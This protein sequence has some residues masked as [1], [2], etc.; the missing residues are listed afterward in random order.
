L[1]TGEVV[2]LVRA[3]AE[4]FVCLIR[5][6][7]GRPLVLAVPF[8]VDRDEREPHETGVVESLAIGR[9]VER[10]ASIGE[11][12]VKLSPPVAEHVA[13]QVLDRSVFELEELAD[14]LVIGLLS[15]LEFDHRLAPLGLVVP[16]C[17]SDEPVAQC[18][19]GPY[20]VFVVAL[21]PLEH[22]L[23]SVLH[24]ALIVDNRS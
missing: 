20:V 1:T 24:V 8:V 7:E 23:V 14:Q 10:H 22:C 6:P 21:D 19:R 4:A 16:L 5:P 9:C 15:A 13:E 3:S 2:V 11:V 18:H 17:G 12:R